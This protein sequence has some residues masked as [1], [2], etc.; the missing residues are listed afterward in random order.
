M[1]N[2]S[3]ATNQHKYSGQERAAQLKLCAENLAKVLDLVLDQIAKGEVC[4]S[5]DPDVWNNLTKEVKELVEKT[6]AHVDAGKSL[7]KKVVSLLESL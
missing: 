2:S 7:K 4:S 3:S 5:D 1:Q 6:D